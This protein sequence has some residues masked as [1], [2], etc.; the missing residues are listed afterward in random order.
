MRFFEKT[1]FYP[2]SGGQPCDKGT[3]EIGNYTLIVKNVKKIGNVRLNPST[4]LKK[5][6]A[7][8]LKFHKVSKQIN[9]PINNYKNRK[10]NNNE[11]FFDYFKKN[12]K[13]KRKMG[14]LTILNKKD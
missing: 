1:L 5:L 4:F 3:L 8:K 2:N 11:F 10:Y 12:I 6:K 14:H 13:E 7:P 9:V